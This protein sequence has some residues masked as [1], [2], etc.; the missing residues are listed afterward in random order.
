MKP[1]HWLL[2]GEVSQEMSM[3]K[4]DDDDER[5]VNQMVHQIN[6]SSR[7][8]LFY[9][10]VSQHQ[11]LHRQ[12]LHSIGITAAWTIGLAIL[13]MRTANTSDDRLFAWIVGGLGLF[14]VVLF[15]QTW[16]RQRKC[17]Q[18]DEQIL[19]RI[20]LLEKGEVILMQDGRVI[21]GDPEHHEG[22]TD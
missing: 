15:A 19:V 4:L 6:G 9:L 5:F 13:S 8:Q 1:K 7:S 14:W 3:T 12:R 11:K 10:A 16:Q 17:T 22:S 20:H 18:V 21:S 2:R